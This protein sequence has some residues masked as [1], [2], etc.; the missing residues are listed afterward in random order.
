MGAVRPGI[1]A[2]TPGMVGA[3]AGAAGVAG[4]TPGMGAVRPG[5]PGVAG[6][7]GAAGA[8]GTVIPGSGAFNPGMVGVDAGAVAGAV[9]VNPGMAERPGIDAGS[10]ARGAG[11]VAPRAVAKFCRIWGALAAEA[12]NCWAMLAGLGPGSGAGSA[13][14]MPPVNSAADE[15]TKTAP[16]R[17]NVQMVGMTLPGYR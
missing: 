6:A 7:A 1:G 17:T 5:M 15:P 12:I 16:A 2:L 3:A 10:A 11:G 9:G 8:T 14:A 4:V 13:W